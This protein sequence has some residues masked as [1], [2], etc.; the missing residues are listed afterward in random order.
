MT[1]LLQRFSRGLPGASQAGDDASPES[2]KSADQPFADYDRLSQRDLMNA[3]SG[4]SQAELE[5]AEA[6]ERSHKN[7]LPVL[8]KLQYMRGRQPLPG[9]D[10]M[11]AEEIVAVL[12]DSDLDMIKAIRAY[13]RKFA[14][15]PVVLDEVA[16]VH[17]HHREANPAAPP[18][19]YQSASANAAKDSS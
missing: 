15:R 13:E 12:Q 6:Y 17:H 10:A 9:Y 1:S 11:S 8:D 5:A 16:H 19:A 14:N 3:L 18:P 4:H 7:R 2:A